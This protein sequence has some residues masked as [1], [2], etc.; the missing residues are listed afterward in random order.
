MRK[1][2]PAEKLELLEEMKQLIEEIIP[3]HERL[4]LARNRSGGL[5]RSL[6]G[7]T[8]LQNA[9]ELEIRRQHRKQVF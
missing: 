3:E 9:K 8:G 1:Y 6:A 7:F 4:W 2:S 5:E